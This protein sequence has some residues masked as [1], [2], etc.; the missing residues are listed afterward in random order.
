[1]VLML[2]GRNA[3]FQTLSIYDQVSHRWLKQQASG[4]VPE[5][6]GSYCSV[7]VKGPQGT[8]EIFI[9]GGFSEITSPRSDTYVLSLPG[10]TWFKVDISAHT[11]VYHAC[12]VIGKRQMLI[13]GGLRKEWEWRL[14]DEWIGAHNI[15][16]LS[17]LKFSDRYD[18]NASAYEPA[19]VIKDWYYQGGMSRMQWTSKEV[20]DAFDTPIDINSTE[21][22]SPPPPSATPGKLESSSNPST[23]GIIVGAT[24]GGVSAI[25]LIALAVFLYRRRQKYLTHASETTP[26]NS[27]TMPSTEMELEA[28]DRP[29]ELDLGAAELELEATD[30]P[31]ELA[32]PRQI[33][34]M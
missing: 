28:A 5:P 19:Q 6:R 24:I 14:D 34:E 4:S 8:L 12:A 11:R 2:G 30:R 22:S 20:Q 32:S 10:F 25:L 7:A 21:S 17:E 31:L 26:P 13:S 15:L 27:K 23:V 3:D 33:H 29:S 16:D 1:M 18:A 9:H